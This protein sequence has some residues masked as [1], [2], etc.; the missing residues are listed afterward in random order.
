[1][2][3]FQNPFHTLS[4]SPRDDR[5][6][7]AELA[8]EQGLLHD[9][10][11]CVKA[12]AELTNPGKRISAEI[13]WLPGLSPAKAAEALL[14]LEADA[15]AVRKM[16]KLTDIV[17]L[18]LLASGLSRLHNLNRVEIAEWIFDISRILDRLDASKICGIINEDRIVSG[19][20]EVTDCSLVENELNN[21]RQYCKSVINNAIESL[22]DLERIALITFVIESATDEGK[23]H[24]PIL[25]HDLVESY[26][27]ETQV[28]LEKGEADIKAFVDKIKT[29]SDNGGG[30]EMLSKMIDDLM[31]TVQQ[32]DDVAQPIQ[33]SKKSLGLTHDASQRLAYAI[34]ALAIH[35]YNE[36]KNLELAQQL[37]TFLQKVFSEVPDVSEL[38]SQDADTLGTYEKEKDRD[39]LFAELKPISSAPS[40]RTIN[41]IGFGLYGESAPDVESGSVLSTYYFLVFFLPVFPICRYRVIK[42]NGSYSFLG[43]APLRN[44]DRW[45]IGISLAIIAMFFLYGLFANN[46]GGIRSSENSSSYNYTAPSSS[47]A[48]NVDASSSSGSDGM[49]AYPDKS[50]QE[51]LKTE[52][53]QG[54]A[55]ANESEARLSEMITRLKSYE[56]QL[57]TYKDAGDSDAYD[58]LVPTYNS[59]LA[60]FKAEKTKY[61]VLVDQVNQQV[62]LYNSVIQSRR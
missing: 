33:V 29:H 8:D 19:F 14:L 13:A 10:D 12:R 59:L 9:P 53:E 45:H 54:K 35:I 50:N 42:N 56:S 25:I 32:W 28:D 43:K 6:R 3:L 4:A 37:T 38:V 41:G 1:M 16:E 30:E 7:I 22:P 18:N 48:S 57:E 21:R 20:P 58:A 44:F 40:L 49:V 2:D 61:D 36:H 51:V 23:E 11:A 27:L 47:P 52:I 17:R 5:R 26:E 31:V 39:R 62:N 15:E 24:G 60:E 55:K 34:R 46:S